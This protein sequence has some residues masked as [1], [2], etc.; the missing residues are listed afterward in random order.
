[1]IWV[2]CKVISERSGS[3]S[4]EARGVEPK[5]SLYLTENSDMI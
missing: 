2:L 5:I 3:R 4:A 1:M